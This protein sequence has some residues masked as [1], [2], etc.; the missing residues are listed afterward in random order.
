MIQGGSILTFQQMKSKYGINNND[1]MKF[2]QVK[3]FIL[4]NLK[5]F[6]GGLA[7]SPIESLLLNNKRLKFFTKK[8]YKTLNADNSDKVKG[9]WESDVGMIESEDWNALCSQPSSVQV[10]NSAWERQFKILHRLFITPEARHKMNLTL[11][12]LYTKCQSAAR[13]FIHCLW[14]CPHI[15]QRP[16]MVS[17]RLTHMEKI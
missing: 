14:S 12:E 1:F 11:S 6:T 15:K 16:R 4:C 5:E 7:I 3:K 8:L 13:S 17:A 2:L 9:K 10:S